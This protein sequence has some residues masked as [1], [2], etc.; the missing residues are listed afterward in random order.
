VKHVKTYRVPRKVL[1]RITRISA[2]SFI[3]V[4]MTFLGLY[5]GLYIDKITNMA[6]NFT[7]LGLIIGIVLGFRGFLH[8]AAVER[9]GES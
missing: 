9:R 3:L 4:I 2:L 8:E 1:N 6:P 5:A 7:L